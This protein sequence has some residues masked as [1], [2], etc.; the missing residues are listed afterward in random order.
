MRYLYQL[1]EVCKL[2][3]VTYNYTPQQVIVKQRRKQ[4]GP[5]FH[6][7]YQTT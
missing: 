2:P 3:T 7:Y 4:K 5:S 1:L 6:I